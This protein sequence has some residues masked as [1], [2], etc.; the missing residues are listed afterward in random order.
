MAPSCRL[1]GTVKIGA[2]NRGSPHT[3]LKPPDPQP[4]STYG[5]ALER[6]RSLYRPK[7]SWHHRSPPTLSQ[8]SAHR[9]PPSQ[10]SSAPRQLRRSSAPQLSHAPWKGVPFP[11]ESS[12]HLLERS[13]FHTRGFHTRGVASSHLLE[14]SCFP[15]RPASAASFVPIPSRQPQP[16][17]Q[18]VIFARWDQ[19]SEHE[20]QSVT[21]HALSSGLYFGPIR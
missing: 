15:S 2:G 3:A 5:H 4:E 19:G 16:Q 10:L 7:D 13:C 14:R 20:K 18:R 12:S 1:Q 17:N 8:G 9:P 6:S 21:Q 11:T